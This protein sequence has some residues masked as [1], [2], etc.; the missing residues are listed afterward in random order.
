MPI[1]I[2]FFMIMTSGV[3][4]TISATSWFTVW[5]GLEINMMAFLPLMIN[6]TNQHT[7]EACLKYFLSQVIASSFL[8]LALTIPPQMMLWPL[9]TEF[10]SSSV[11]I[12]IALVLKLGAAP[13]HFWFPPTME[14]LEWQSCILLAT[15]QK[16][17]PLI[18]LSMFNSN[19]LIISALM[20][21]LAGAIGGYNQTLMRKLMAYSSIGHLSWMLMSTI[22]SQSFTMFY[23][24]TY[25]YLSSLMMLMFKMMNIYHVMQMITMPQATIMFLMMLNML[26]LGGL[27]PFLGFLP[28]WMLIQEMANM[29]ML[30]QALV[31]IMSSLVTLFYYLRI[32]YTTLLTSSSILNITP[33]KTPKLLIISSIPSLLTLPIIMPALIM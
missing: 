15:I 1:K 9:T 4:I 5:L 22:L 8:L 23:I 25:I 18:L 10:S 30:V 19:V 17:S 3:I 21:A 33:Y 7:Y 28:K 16:I 14:G 11:I 27:P 31:M 26:S 29:N 13:F 12:T 24:M 32:T 2:M 20:S 6:H